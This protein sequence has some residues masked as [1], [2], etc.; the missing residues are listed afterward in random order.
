MKSVLSRAA[1]LNK[2]NF[3]QQSGSDHHIPDPVAVSWYPV[4][5][6]VQNHSLG[7]LQQDSRQS[8]ITDMLA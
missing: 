1:L 2:S 7:Y 4:A 5:K 8:G 6:K 3:R